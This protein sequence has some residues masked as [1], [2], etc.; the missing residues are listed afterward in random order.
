MRTPFQQ[1]PP[2][3]GN[4]YLEDRVLRSYLR[5]TLPAAM[6]EAIEAELVDLGELAGGPL[7]R[8]SLAERLD[9]LKVV[10]READALAALSAEVEACRAAVRD[11]ALRVAVERADRALAHAQEF[12]HG[13]GGSSPALEAGAR[14]WA[15]TLGRAFSLAL[16]A[17]HAQWSLDHEADRRPRAAALR[18]A[19]TAVDLLAGFALEDSESLANDRVSPPSEEVVGTDARE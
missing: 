14:R 15:M 17:R 1:S 13:K 7:Y 11:P 6:R 2:E 18:F 19:E 9:A 5:R 8:Q 12:L 10:A 4:Q 16:L 3:L